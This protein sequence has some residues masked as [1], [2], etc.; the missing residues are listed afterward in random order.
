MRGICSIVDFSAPTMDERTSDDH[1]VAWGDG[2]PTWEF[3]YVEDTAE[4][5]LLA[6]EC[7]NVSDPVNPSRGPS[8]GSGQAQ[9]RR[10]APGAS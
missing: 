9:C 8:P 2:S 5:I 7:Y 3:L 4:G 10:P 1:I 6:A